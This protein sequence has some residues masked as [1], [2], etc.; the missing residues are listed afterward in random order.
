MYFISTKSWSTKVFTACSVFLA[1]FSVVTRAQVMQT[2]RFEVPVEGRNERYNIIPSFEQ[3]LYL[4]RQL[5]GPREDQIQ[6]IKLDTAFQQEWGGFIPVEKNF[7]VMGTQAFGQHLYMLLRYR[8]F[9]R[10]NLMLYVVDESDGRFVKYDIRGYIPFAPTAFQVT[11]DAAIIGGYYNRIPVVLHYS[12]TTFRSKVLP[13]LFTE[14]G[15]LTQINTHDDGSFDVL[16][17]AR[18]LDRQRTIWIKSYDADGDLLRNLALQPEENKHLIFGRSIKIPGEKQIV[19]GVYGNRS[20]EFSRGLFIATIEPSGYEQIRYYN[21]GDLKN[22]FHYMKAKREKRIKDRIERKKIKGKKI[23]FNYRFL[24][25]ELVPYGDQFVLLGEAFYP[26]YV[27]TDHAQYRF[28]GPYG[29]IPGGFVQNGR[30]F[31]GYYYT[32]AVVMGFD[33]S[34]SLLWDNSF[35]IN[36][37]KTYTLEQFVK[38]EVL[39]DRLALM[40]VFENQI[41][42]KIIKNDMVLEGKTSDPILTFRAEDIVRDDDQ[43]NKLE[44]WY[45]RYM[46]AYGVQDI[47]TPGARG[48]SRR[49]VFFINKLYYPDD[50]EQD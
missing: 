35:E 25:H 1:F 34:G 23:R 47:E 29:G 45:N 32:H 17:S 33:A 12:L 46:Y 2:G 9:T 40:Y 15:E 43:T 28:F 8:D 36:D 27:S 3:G 19:A 4:Q 50:G 37:V 13:G 30:I 5:V 20:A 10:N 48:S 39:P 26:R 7:R 31:D 6:L 22:F 11:D 38:L 21:F 44:Y 41:R 42:T 49:R 18:N 14:A 16:I 24:V